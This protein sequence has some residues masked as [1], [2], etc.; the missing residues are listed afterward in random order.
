MGSNQKDES[1]LRPTETGKKLTKPKD[2]VEA[3]SEGRE[4]EAQSSDTAVER[5]DLDW[6]DH[7]D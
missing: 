4:A 1:A 2:P 5:P 3:D 6:A 7:E